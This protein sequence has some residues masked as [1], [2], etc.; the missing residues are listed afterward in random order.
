MLDKKE[1][2]IEAAD[3]IAWYPPHMKVRYVHW[4]EN[5]QWDWC[6]SRQRFFGVPFPVWH[7]R[8]CGMIKLADRSQLPVDPTR[9]KPKT[10]CGCGCKDF[11]PEQD[12]MDT[13]AT[14]S[15]TPQIALQWG[16]KGNMF[17]RMFPMSVRFQAHDIIRTWA[18]Y[19]I[20][21]AV[22]HHDDVPWKNIMIAGH[23]L[24]PHGKKMSKSKGNVVDPIQTMQKYCADALRFWAATSRLGDDLPFQEK[25]LV[26]GMKFVTKL[27]NASRFAI[28][29]LEDY[30][31]TKGELNAMDRCMLSKM[32]KLVRECTDAFE[33]YEYSRTKAAA[34]NFFWHMICDNYLEITKGRLYDQNAAHLPARR[35]AQYAIYHLLLTTIQLMAPIMPHIT[36]AVYQLYFAAKDGKESIHLS[37]WPEYDATMVDESAEDIGEKAIAIIATVRRQK[38]EKDLSLNAPVK[39]L[40][41]ECSEEDQH[42]LAPLFE[43][44]KAT[45]KAKDVV[46]GKGSVETGIKEIKIG[47]LF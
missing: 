30:D 29:N 45:C 1:E 46:F 8:K 38:A 28:M 12:V 36:E 35:G 16:E 6:I 26:T 44:I 17:G 39:E 22:F 32:T 7:C 41:I 25:D 34:E 4:V 11:I 3:K 21:K 2:L 40:I 31:E 15:V 23:A 19:T 42:R 10:A 14:S 37:A 47:I 9:D 13:W 24:D 18:F 5:L 20:V 33:A 43:D 27:W